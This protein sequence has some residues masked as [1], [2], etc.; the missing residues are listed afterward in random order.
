MNGRIETPPPVQDGDCS[1]LYYVARA[2]MRIQNQF[3]H[4]PEIRGKGRCAKVWLGFGWLR[5][6]C[7]CP[8]PSCCSESNLVH[9]PVPNPDLSPAFASATAPFRSVANQSKDSFHPRPAMPSGSLSFPR[10]LFLCILAKQGVCHIPRP[11]FPSSFQSFAVGEGDDS[12]RQF[13]EPFM[14]Q[15]LH[16]QTPQLPPYSQLARGL[17]C[18]QVVSQC[19]AHGQHQGAVDTRGSACREGDNSG[20]G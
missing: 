15:F 9:P 6:H 13:F 19:C 5:G 1:S 11:P 16:A 3:G 17:I 10:F 7:T 14:F 8:W 4:I 18:T 2:L 12:K 20:W